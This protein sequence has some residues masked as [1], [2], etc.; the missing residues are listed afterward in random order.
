MLKGAGKFS[1]TDI[2]HCIIRRKEY[3]DIVTIINDVDP[4]LFYYAEEIKNVRGGIFLNN[5]VKK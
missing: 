5:D 1:D 4:N 2:L 3:A